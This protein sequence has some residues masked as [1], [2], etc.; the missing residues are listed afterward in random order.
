MI[1][2]AEIYIGLMSGT[3]VDSID[4]AAMTF[5][6]GQLQLIGTHSQAIPAI[7]KRNIIDLCQPGRDSVLLYCQTDN[8][9]GELF[10]EAAVALMN[11][12]TIAPDQVAAIGSHGQTIRHAPP[13]ASTIAF[14]QQIG[15]ANII[16]ART[17]CKVVADF[18]RKD[19][20]LGGHGAPLVPAFHQTL[21]SDPIKS[22]VIANIGG[23]SNITVLANGAH[24]YGFDTGPGNLLLDAWCN[25][26][27]GCSFDDKGAWGASGQSDNKLLSR[28]KSHPFMALPAP[29]TTG[30][31]AFN[32]SWLEQQLTDLDLV[33]EDVQ[34]TLVNFTA[35][36]LAEAIRALKEP[37]DEV[38]VC[39]GGAFNDELM[40]QLQSD[41][42]AIPMQSTQRLG[43]DP[44]WVEAC[45]FAWLARQRLNGLPGNLPRVTG[46]SRE[47]R[48]GALYLP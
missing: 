36:T 32:L 29:K 30:R 41:L 7:L 2:A 17:G 4:A 19:M 27:T 16:A 22:R 48:L 5:D 13:G 26:H 39:G 10:A 9:L 23:I 31:E 38:Y 37:I 42:G 34:A 44:A 40:T 3:S 1:S 12:E 6:D 46:A 35:Q 18:R 15:D 43:L 14:T 24:C 25:K 33:V 8:Q 47:T 11:A 21:F 28:L 20:A 45:A